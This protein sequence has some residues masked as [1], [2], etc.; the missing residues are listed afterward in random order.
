MI[1]FTRP[2]TRSHTEIRSAH[3][4]RRA[5]AGAPDRQTIILRIKREEPTRKHRRTTLTG[6][7]RYSSS[8]LETTAYSARSSEPIPLWTLRT[9]ATLV[10]E[11][12]NQGRQMPATVLSGCPKDEA[13]WSQARKT[14][15]NQK[16]GGWGSG[17]TTPSE[18]AKEGEP[19]IKGAGCKYAHATQRTTSES[20][21]TGKA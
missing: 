10:K 15:F 3:R 1:G 18:D 17:T 20:T 5:A 7:T 9:R 8:L 6:S 4:P 2:E 14:G 21:S 13:S 12:R 11:K 16:S 19:E